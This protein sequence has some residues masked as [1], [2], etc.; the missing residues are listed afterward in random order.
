MAG[1]DTAQLP[2]PASA[3]SPD[4]PAHG[5]QAWLWLVAVFALGLVVGGVLVAVLGGGD[6][7]DAAAPRTTRVT[8]TRTRAP[9]GGPTSAGADVHVSAACVHAIDDAR[10]ALAVLGDAGDAVR[11]FDLSALGSVVQRARTIEQRLRAELP[12]CDATVRLASGAPPS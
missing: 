1:S 11:H 3:R 2:D 4:R 8:V 10:S 7:K 5:P 12:G 6:S 9:D